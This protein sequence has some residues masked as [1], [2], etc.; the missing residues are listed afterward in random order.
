MCLLAANWKVDGSASSG[1]R[2]GFIDGILAVIVDHG[3]RGESED[4]AN[5]VA[6]RVSEMG[7]LL[8][9]HIAAAYFWFMSVRSYLVDD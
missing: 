5:C 2:R 6:T 4:E 9:Y 8:V 7:K 3:L 1:E